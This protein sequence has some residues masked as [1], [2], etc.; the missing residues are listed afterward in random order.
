MGRPITEDQINMVLCYSMM[1]A[2]DFS[3][4]RRLEWEIYGSRH[5]PCPTCFSPPHQSCLNM[6]DVKYNSTRPTTGK[7]Q[8]RQ[9]KRPHDSRIDWLIILQGLKKRGYYRASIEAQVRRQV[10]TP[11]SREFVSSTLPPEDRPMPDWAKGE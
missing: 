8:V 9:N 2:W 6:S 7:R 4:S 5:Q 10:R 11:P 3:Y 1:S